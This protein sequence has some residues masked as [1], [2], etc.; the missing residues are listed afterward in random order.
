MHRKPNR[1]KI[2]GIGI[3]EVLIALVVVSIGVL[4]LAGTQL[5]VMR[6][7]KGSNN[8]SQ[9][10]FYAE[11]IIEEMRANP[12]AVSTMAF[13]GLDSATFNCN[14]AP[15]PYCSAYPGGP[16]V[17]PSCL[18][19]A[20]KTSNG[21]FSVACGQW[22]GAESVNGISDNLPAGTIAVTCDNAPCT[23]TSTYT[24]T[25]T[26]S[27]TEIVDDLD[28]GTTKQVAMRVLP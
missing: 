27:E 24:I 26:W 21:F 13:D 25:V 17:T 28:V 3:L 2:R 15:A 19:D 23:A 18:T 10:V 6:V 11:T 12:S 1:L 14:A 4:G 22:T 9:A 20:A 5:N 16:A 8:R 7:A